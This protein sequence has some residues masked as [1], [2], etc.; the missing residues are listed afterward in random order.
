V[1]LGLGTAL[2]AAAALIR[3]WAE[4]YLHSSVV[5]DAKLIFNTLRD[6]VAIS[7]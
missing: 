5:H 2:A 6:K 4:A 7:Y 3:S 1:I